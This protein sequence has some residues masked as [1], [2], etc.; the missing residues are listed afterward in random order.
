MSSRNAAT[1][2]TTPLCLADI[3]LFTASDRAATGRA[4][5]IV[6]HAIRIAL[7]RPDRTGEFPVLLVFRKVR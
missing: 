7:P 1:A 5:M 3:V 6:A 2:P 4:T